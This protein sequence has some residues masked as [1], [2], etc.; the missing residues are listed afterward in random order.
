MIRG[1]RDPEV[2]ELPC[3]Q[4][5]ISEQS[6]I[7]IISPLEILS[8][9]LCCCYAFKYQSGSVWTGYELGSDLKEEVC[10]SSE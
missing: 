1:N 4:Y 10:M 7:A 2:T 9:I 8:Q 6:S 5:Y 3:S